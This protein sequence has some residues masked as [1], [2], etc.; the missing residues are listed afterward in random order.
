MGRQSVQED[1]LI[2]MEQLARPRQLDEARLIDLPRGG[3]RGGVRRRR[4]REA[5]YALP[6]LLVV[7]ETQRRERSG[8]YAR[9]LQRFPAGSHFEVGFAIVGDALGNAPRGVPVVAAGRV[10]DQHFDPLL[11]PTVEQ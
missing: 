4:S 7:D 3:A 10:D 8:R 2:G 6:A 1:A 11:G 5:E 9:L